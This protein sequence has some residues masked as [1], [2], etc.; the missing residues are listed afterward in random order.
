MNELYGVFVGNPCPYN[1]TI[2]TEISSTNVCGN[3]VVE[4][5]E[6]CDDGLNDGVHGCKSECTTGALASF[7]CTTNSPSVC[8][9]N[10]GPIS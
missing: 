1:I 10:L 7:T 9:H 3:G 2:N 5:P 6:N 4:S 8:T